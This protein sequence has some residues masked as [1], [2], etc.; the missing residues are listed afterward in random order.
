MFFLEDVSKENK[1]FYFAILVSSIW[2]FTNAFRADI[3]FVIAV[4]VAI[5][6]ILYDNQKN[7]STIDNLNTGLHYK[8]NSLLE[9][10][11]H[12]TP[13]YLY[14]EPDMINF[15]YSIRDFRI[16]NR[17]SYLK[18][19]KSVDDLLRIKLEL[20]YD[21]KYV[22]EPKLSGWQNFG[23]K[24][25]AK[26]ENNIKNHKGMFES[27]EVSGQNAINYIH[28]FA[29]ALPEGVYSEKHK[30]SLERIHILIKKVLD[31]IL[32]TCKKSSSD[33]MLG[34]TYGLPKAHRKDTTSFEFVYLS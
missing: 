13:K 4:S 30:K 33:P 8:L 25:K 19:I 21:Y 14:L 9:K 32:R 3:K 17:D 2:F 31:D 28:S 18:A 1:L 7:K 23:N 22:E 5:F 26:I 16:Y 15:F 27:A 29:I 6:I 34:Q 20:E 11:N 24:P 10:E 12:P